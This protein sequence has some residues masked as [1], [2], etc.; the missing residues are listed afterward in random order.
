MRI[1][2]DEL[3]KFRKPSKMFKLQ[4][5]P[6]RTYIFYTTFISALWFAFCKRVERLGVS[7]PPAMDGRQI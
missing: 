6:L 1:T 2:N 3:E 4:R 7:W 5:S